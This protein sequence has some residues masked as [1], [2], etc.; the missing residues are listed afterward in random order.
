MGWER[1]SAHFVEE[2]CAMKAAIT[3]LA[4]D[5]IG[6]E[7]TSQAVTVMSRVASKF[8][9]EFIFNDAIMGGIA[10]DKTGNPC[11]DETLRT[12]EQGDAILLGAV[13]GP[14]WSD[15]TA[16]VRPEQGLLR[17]RKHFDLFANLR[18]VKAYPAL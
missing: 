9:H 18:P 17:V 8:G 10:I 2:E 1:F 5:G 4:G 12:C 6:P 13:G 11:P 16:P 15:P 7:G 3:V 14:K